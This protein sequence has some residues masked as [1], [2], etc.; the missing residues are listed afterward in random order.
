M[1]VM[2]LVLGLM[3]AGCDTAGTRA[4]RLYD[5]GMRQLNQGNLRDAE[6]AFIEVVR[7]VPE[8]TDAYI[9]MGDIAYKRKDMSRALGMYR[10]ALEYEPGNGQ[11]AL[12]LADMAL[13]LGA[14]DLVRRY[15][16]VAESVLGEEPKVLSLRYNLEYRDMLFKGT[17]EERSTVVAATIALL[18]KAP[19]L[20]HARRLIIDDLLR[21][22]DFESAL[23]VVTQGISIDPFYYEFYQ[24]RIAVL[25]E[26]GRRNDITLQLETMLDLFPD[27]ETVPYTLARWY[28]AEGLTE[29]AETLLRSRAEEEPGNL[30]RQTDLIRFLNDELGYDAVVAELERLRSQGGENLVAF[31]GMHAGLLFDNG[32]SERA[33]GLLREIIDEMPA[34]ERSGLTKNEFR[35]DLA[36]ML[37]QTDRMDESKTIIESVLTE[38]PGHVSAIK[39]KAAW[40]I[41][42]DQ[43][44]TGVEM[45]RQALRESPRD[46]Q[47]MTLISLGHERAGEWDLQ[48]EMLS[49]AVEASRSGVQESLRYAS[50][51]MEEERYGP[52]ESILINAYRQNTDNINL[53]HQLGR[54]Y[55]YLSNWSGAQNVI[56]LLEAIAT[57][58]AQ[59]LREEAYKTFIS[60]QAYVLDGQKRDD[61]LFKFLEELSNT[62]TGLNADVAII[63]AYTV[64]GETIKARERLLQARTK[65]PEN[66][67]LRFLD[68]SI[69]IIDGLF[70]QAELQ[71]E[72]L[73]VELPDAEQVW[74]ALYRLHLTQDNAEQASVVLKRAMDQLPNGYSVLFAL[75][76]EY[77]DQGRIDDAITVY[78]RL[79]EANRSVEVIA[80][81]LASLISQYKDD[82]ENLEQAYIISRR[83]RNSKVPAFRDTYG[84]IMVRRGDFKE[85]EPHLEIALEAY[86]DNAV[87]QYHYAVMLEGLGREEEALTHFRIARNL[88][89]DD[90]RQDIVL[91]RIAALEEKGITGSILQ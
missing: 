12:Q 27:E 73:L 41:D 25:E 34:D 1:L 78:S 39:L 63:R 77:E 9:A 8:R 57:D 16:P 89:L 30:R 82:P 21:K 86:E 71:L 26:L 36:R 43:V 75:A 15:T 55:V 42:E 83:L 64:R 38:D 67:L 66:V 74:M 60:I 79:Y 14:W 24:I 17:P 13:P 5:Q 85:A 22:D 72:E 35:V 32:E 40:L 91:N 88:G 31:S 44:E 59:N 58:G 7:L 49:L 20:I 29:R 62:E 18:E 4:D 56:D 54:I 51:L 69:N 10:K 23:E 6:Q 84:W 28:V 61:E 45:L 46:A 70:D 76:S 37:A 47:L 68:A 3:V 11:A 48:R 2:V 65:D 19:Y 50:V 87:V 81:N 52:A 33:I 90:A 53:L 80:N